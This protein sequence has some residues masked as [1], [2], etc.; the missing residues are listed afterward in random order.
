M[1]RKKIALITINPEDEFGTRVMDG[2]FAQCNACDFD[3]VVISPL[4]HITHYFKDYLEGEL[5]I[6]D[7]INFDLFDGV[8]ITPIP[9]REEQQNFL[10]DALLAK[11]KAECHVPVVS[12]NEPFGDYPV[13]YADESD[14][15]KVITEHLLSVHNVKDIIVLTGPQ[16]YHISEQRAMAVKNTLMEHGINLSDDR[17]VYGDFWYTS[18][19]KLGNDI[20][21]GAFS[22]PDAV[23][24]TSD[25]MGIGLLH[26][27]EKHGYKVPEDIIIT[28]N[29]GSREAFLSIPP[30]TT[31]EPDDYSLGVSAVNII[32]KE[33]SPEQSVTKNDNSN[34]RSLCVC[35]TCG[36]PEDVVKI[37]SKLR[38]FMYTD[39]YSANND[40]T[41]TGISLT[42]LLDSYIL[43]IFS[44][45]KNVHD[46]LCRIYETEYLLKPYNYFYICLNDNWLE[47][48]NSTTYSSRMRIAV[49]SDYGVTPYGVEHHVFYEKGRERYFNTVDMLPALSG[50]FDKPQVFY[51]VPLHV[52]NEPIGYA[53]L[54]NN[55]DNPQ[56]IGVVYRNYI[57]Y[58]CNALD[59]TRAKS[60]IQ[61]ISE[62]DPMTNLYNRRGM[63]RI[64]TEWRSSALMDMKNGIAQDLNYLAVM[65]DM[66]CLKKINDTHGHEAGDM[67]IKLISQAVLQSAVG[68]EF[69]VRSGGD[70]FYILGI[71]NYT[72]ADGIAHVNAIKST[73]ACLNS[74]V[75]SNVSYSAAVGYA[76]MPV[77][78]DS[79]YHTVLEHADVAMYTDKGENRR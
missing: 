18:G 67:G 41:N 55:L 7:I 53:V 30:V 75:Q 60:Y 49:T 8:I 38:D 47:I 35:G 54:Q 57:R 65:I 77:T 32:A 45:Q 44:A 29:G 1:S 40:P 5:K 14:G 26:C 74:S 2:I 64:I 71:G 12:I 76:I 69:A 28:G 15:M 31:F 68:R 3:V 56:R 42:E 16:N 10:T 73:L 17:I 59:V 63:K 58:L 22:K 33:I 61:E 43:E 34:K 66:N 4:V 50:D 70:E 78:E 21:S 25:H 51:F 48:N 46:C 62:R 36:C 19:E 52:A 20:A 9:M 37:R 6:Y 27:L 24:C 79:D 23:I 39:T 13:V 72:E 11:I